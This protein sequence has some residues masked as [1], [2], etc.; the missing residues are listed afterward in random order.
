MSDNRGLSI[1][2]GLVE[3][4]DDLITVGFDADGLPKTIAARD[5]PPEV[6][7]KEDAGTVQKKKDED[8]LVKQLRKERDDRAREAEEAK[9]QALDAV[10]QAQEAAKARAQAEAAAAKNH[11]Y[12]V[13]SHMQRMHAERGQVES[14]LAAAKAS[15]AQ[16]KD[17]L[18]RAVSE[19]DGDRVADIT[20]QMALASADLREFERGKAGIEAEIARHQAAFEAADEPAAKAAPEPAAAKTPT[21]DDW[22]E[23]CPKATHAWLKDHR[24]YVTDPKLNRKL[25]RF[26]D[27]YMED[28]G[29]AHA[30][31]TSDFIEALNAKFFPKKE[32]RAPVTTTT[33]DKVD[34]TITVDEGVE[35][36]ARARVPA[37]AP[38][39][40]SGGVFSSANPTA[41]HVKLPAKLAQFVKESGLDP[42]KY[43]LGAVA[44][45]KA[46][47]LPKNFLD[48]DYPHEF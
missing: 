40:A 21:P 27:E 2:D 44:D 42:V 48:P 12:A 33:E 35:E 9:Q 45:I 28:N 13:N 19:G 22:I 46:G 4:P 6:V 32:E 37:A 18:K 15:V 24:D 11:G 30:L 41:K 3:I 43:A 38:V 5:Q 36:K 39:R 34:A 25:M 31:N 20:E 29:G 26:A 8:E 10:R 1:D 23:S 47:K 7:A 14:G 16:L 17:M